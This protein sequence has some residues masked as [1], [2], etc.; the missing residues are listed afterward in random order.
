[1]RPSKH[2]DYYSGRCGKNVVCPSPCGFVQDAIDEELDVEVI[3]PED[4][5]LEDN[6]LLQATLASYG[7]GEFDLD[8]IKA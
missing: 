1:M 7:F 8:V 5:N 4:D 3:V 6:A 2:C